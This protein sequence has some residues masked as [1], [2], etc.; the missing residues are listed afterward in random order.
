MKYLPIGIQ[1]LTEIRERNCVY[2]D[3][4]QLIHQLVTEGKHYFFS[5]PRRFGKSLLVSTLKELYSGNKSIFE[6]LWIENNWDW[7]KKHP[8]IH[9]S[10]DDMTYHQVGINQAITDEINRISKS[11]DIEIDARFGPHNHKGNLKNLIEKVS[12]KYG[13]VVFLVDE[14]DKP[15]LD[16]LETHTMDSAKVNQDVLR[17]FYGVLKNADSHL[18]FVFI[19]GISKFSKVSL[20]SHLNNLKDITL[21]EKYSTIVGYTQEELEL[22]FDDY[23]TEIEIKLQTTREILLGT[24]RE[25]Y[26]GFSWDG[27]N[28]VYNPFGTLNFLSNKVFRNFWFSTGS[29]RF[30]VEK[31]KKETYSHIENLVVDNTSLDSYDLDNIKMISLLFETGNLTIKELDPYTGEMILNYP[32]KEVRESMNQILINRG[33]NF[34]ND[35]KEIDERVEVEL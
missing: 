6:G 22:Y 26:N 5:R 16:F 2:V 20:F 18:E 29:P 9:F 28:S 27:I 30:L 23:L 14:Y 8:V 34:N 35:L 21:S 33:V 15:I 3:K 1:D 11:F 17:E 31:M 4:T 25:W 13:K 24:M 12:G 7:T 10:F 32:N 19:T